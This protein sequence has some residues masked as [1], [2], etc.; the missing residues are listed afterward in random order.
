MEDKK[1]KA[2]SIASKIKSLRESANWSQ[3]ELAR[4]AGVTSAA[5]SQLEKGDR[6][7]SLIV[8]RKLAAALKVSV[9]ELTGEDVPSSSEINSTAQ[10]FFREYGDISNLSKQDQEI[11]KGLVKRMKGN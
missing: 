2:A 11:I 9:N 8:S 3:S 1:S 4:Q 5:I 10:V 7:P 6:T